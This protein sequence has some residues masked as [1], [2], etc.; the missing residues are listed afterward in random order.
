MKCGYVNL[1]SRTGPLI[2]RKVK[3]VRYI[4]FNYLQQIE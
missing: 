1:N 3:T 2:R 4:T